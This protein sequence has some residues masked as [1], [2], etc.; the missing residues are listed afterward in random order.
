MVKKISEEKRRKFKLYKF[1]LS[2]K[3]FFFL[4]LLLYILHTVKRSIDNTKPNIQFLSFISQ[5]KIKK[6]KK[7]IKLFKK[8][9]QT[10]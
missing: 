3:K 4:L 9:F 8:Q 1:H 2:L 6:K 7:M 5:F 10:L